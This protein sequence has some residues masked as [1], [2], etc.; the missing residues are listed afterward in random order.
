MNS[1]QN[2]SPRLPMIV[3][4]RSELSQ[5]TR[6]YSRRSFVAAQTLRATAKANNTYATGA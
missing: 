3:P 1:T 2:T 4:V 6:V 5:P